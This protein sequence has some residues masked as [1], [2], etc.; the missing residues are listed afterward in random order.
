MLYSNN[1]NDT[2]KFTIWSIEFNNVVNFKAKNGPT[3]TVI[4]GSACNS[5]RSSLFS[6]QFLRQTFLN[7]SSSTGAIIDSVSMP[8]VNIKLTRSSKTN[9]VSNRGDSVE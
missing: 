6:M 1:N 3:F 8:I 4:G 9:R 2:V 7:F 5:F